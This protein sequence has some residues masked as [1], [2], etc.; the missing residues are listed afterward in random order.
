ME[1]QILCHCFLFCEQ[2][3]SVVFNG[4]HD[5]R[6][7]AADS[8]VKQHTTLLAVA[9]CLGRNCLIWIPQFIEHHVQG[10]LL[11]SDLPRPDPTDSQL[12]VANDPDLDSGCN[13]L[14]SGFLGY[15]LQRIVVIP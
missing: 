4:D 3:L 12:T 15:M 14:P 2:R 5:K 6:T 11:G 9:V 10:V 13:N 1:L 8:D 7:T